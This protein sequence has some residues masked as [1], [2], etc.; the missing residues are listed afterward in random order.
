MSSTEQPSSGNQPSHGPE[1]V[2]TE[3]VFQ[4][5]PPPPVYGYAPAG[6]AE[7]RRRGIFWI[8]GKAIGVIGVAAFFVAVGYYGAMAT[9]LTG[10]GDG[11]RR[12]VYQRGDPEQAIAIIPVE[13]MI[14]WDSAAMMRRYVDAAID[15]DR[16]KAVVLR[17]DSGGGF[18]GPSEQ[19]H[20]QL[21]RLARSGKPIVAS[22]GS[23]AASGAYYTTCQADYIYAQPVCVT[24][25]IGVLA[26]AVTVEKWL[27][28]N[29]IQPIVLTA[30][31]AEDKDT[32][33]TLL[34]QWTDKDK[35]TMRD[36]LDAMHARFVEIVRAGRVKAGAM[37]EA[38]LE[39]VT[40]GKSYLAEEAVTN[41]LV[42]EIGYLEDAIAEARTRAQITVAEPTVL[43]Y[44]PPVS[45]LEQMG[46]VSGGSTRG[47][48]VNVSDLDGE[49]I[50][51]TLMELATPRMMYLYRP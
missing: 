44:G 20:H 38:Q 10:S 26:Q 23:L 49:R 43:E 19:M 48:S 28:D 13:G 16:I 21:Q 31:T 5:P 30:R 33:N 32:A 29:G 45:V 8:L 37:T 40:T 17:V 15:N 50:R 22:Y 46:L 3:Q 27:A 36:Q 51:Q 2:Q 47:V 14:N 7:P 35:Q 34:R 9:V 1:P 6:G 11:L 24:G 42:D 41:R 39:Q 4:P 12:Q 25:S 18:I